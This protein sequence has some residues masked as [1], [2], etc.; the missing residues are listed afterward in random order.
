MPA[1]THQTMKTTTI[2][3]SL[4]S[5]LILTVFSSAA[6][7]S[8][9]RI[10]SGVS[11]GVKTFVNAAPEDWKAWAE[12]AEKLHPVTDDQGH[13]PDIG[14][15]E[16]ANAL[17]KQ[18]KIGDAVGKGPK[19]GSNEWR[20]SVEM[21]LM[22]KNN[23]GP[24]KDRE[25]LSFH[26]T[27]ASFMGLSDHQCMGRTSL[28]PDRCGESGKLAT[29]KIVKYLDYKK[30]GEYGDPKQENFMVLIEDNMKH[31]KVPE[32]TREVILALNPGELVHLQ[33]NHD[34]V[35]HDGSKFPERLIVAITPIKK[36]PVE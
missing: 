35:T 34:Y 3:L 20:K 29:F 1:A 33:W 24:K 22:Q 21:K 15:D 30:P 27:E 13:G 36:K 12:W 31:P 10:S 6:N 16:W 18:L 7:E 2:V 19:A 26:D 32:A 25:L 14:S 17:S 9:F 4:A 8:I 28:C 5:T 11:T 23:S